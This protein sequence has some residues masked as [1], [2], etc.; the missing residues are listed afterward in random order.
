MGRARYLRDERRWFQRGSTDPSP[1]GGSCAGVVSRWQVDCFMSL[2]DGT[3]KGRNRN[4]NIYIVDA[5]GENEMRVTDHPG[6]DGLPTWVIP[7]R[8]L[9]VDTRGNHAILWGH[10]KSERQ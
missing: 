4:W 8:S 3:F 1:I 9:P 2:R 5:N 7:D 10:L 6:L